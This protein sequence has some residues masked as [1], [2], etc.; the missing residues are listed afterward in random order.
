MHC[1]AKAFSPGEYFL[2]R[3]PCANKF[4]DA[5]PT[6]KNCD[7]V[8]SSKARCRNIDTIWLS[9]QVQLNGTIVPGGLRWL[10]KATLSVSCLLT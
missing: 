5:D 1:I 2:W 3:R 7:S 9:L 6:W 10:E 8:F 4:E